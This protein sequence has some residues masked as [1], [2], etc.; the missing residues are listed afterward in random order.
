MSSPVTAPKNE[1][2]PVSAEAY[3]LIPAR[4][5]PPTV[6]LLVPGA[7]TMRTGGYGYDRAI[8]AGL[9]ELGWRVDICALDGGFPF[10]TVSARAHAAR[11]L[12]ALPDDALVLADGLAFGAM[13]QEAEH[14]ASR[15][16]FIALVHHPLALE[17]GLDPAVAAA[18]FDTERRALA[19][20]RAVVVTSGAT[21]RAL[22]PYGVPPEDVAVIVPGTAAAIVARGTRGIDPPR[23]E[24]PVELLSVAALTPRKGYDVLLDALARLTHLPWHLTCAGS[25]DLHPAT[26]EGCRRQAADLALA[27]RVTFAGELDEP[28]LAAAYDRADVFVLPTRFEGY[29]MAVAEAVAHG[30][31]VISTPTGAIPDL[32]DARSG[33]LIPIDD[34]GALAAALEALIADDSLRARLAIGARARRP[35]LPTWADAAR[36]MAAVLSRHAT[37]AIASCN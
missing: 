10:P 23:T 4:D 36:A 30:L 27:A 31:P 19:T 24:I 26:A 18:L 37:R 6:A 21:S 14:E 29:G 17:S 22:E 34:A 35:T 15:L 32:V 9:Q 3:Q 16:R 28:A 20:A 1:P 8:V 12:A 11:A 33:I 7:I 2:G 25:T 13:A 5:A